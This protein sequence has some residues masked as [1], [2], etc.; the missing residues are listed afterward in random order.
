MFYMYLITFDTYTHTHTFNNTYMHKIYT[1]TSER[2]NVTEENAIIMY[3]SRSLI[4][5]A[6]NQTN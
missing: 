3:Y 2:D 6:L 4:T 5:N 1:H